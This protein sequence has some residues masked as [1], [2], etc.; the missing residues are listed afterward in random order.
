MN[1][2]N[3][4]LFTALLLLLIN[5]FSISIKEGVTFTSY[6]NSKL[7]TKPWDEFCIQPTIDKHSLN[8]K[9]LFKSWCNNQKSVLDNPSCTDIFYDPF[10]EFRR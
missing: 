6:D 10:I 3:Y 5:I 1:L 2:I 9:P 4:I 8:I 7:I